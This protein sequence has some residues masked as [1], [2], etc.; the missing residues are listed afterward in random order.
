M[1]REEH[2]AW[3]KSRALEYVERGAMVDAVASMASD[4]VKHPDWQHSDSMAVLAI[5]GMKATESGPD[6]VRRWIEGFA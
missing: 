1:S 3:A 5:V 6:A 4:L 2:L